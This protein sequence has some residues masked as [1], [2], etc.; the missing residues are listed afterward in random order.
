MLGFRPPDGGAAR[1][2][3]SQV[4]THE[5][6]RPDHPSDE[7]TRRLPSVLVVLVTR[8]GMGWLRGCLASLSRQTYPRLGIIAVD[9]GSTD[10]SRELL[11][12]VLGEA[13]VIQLDANRGF[14][15]SVAAALGTRVASRADYLLLLH[16]DV[17]LDPDAVERLVEAAERVHGAGIVGP[18]VVEWED[19]VVLREVGLST[20]RFG[21]A[22]SPLEEGEIDHGQYDRLREVL[23]VSSC[24]MLVSRDAWGRIGPPDERL[25]ERFDDLDYCW[26]ARL[27][28]FR[29]LVAPLARVRHRAAT[30]RIERTDSEPWAGRGRYYSERAALAAMLKNYSLLSLLWIMPLYA[31][32]SVGKVGGLIAS[33]RFEDAAQVVRA[34]AWNLLRLPGTVRRRVRAQ[35][36]RA[37][38]DRAVRRY[39]ASAGLRLRRWLDVANQLLLGRA[40]ARQEIDEEEETVPTAAVEPLRRRAVSVARD[41]PVGVAWALAVPV[42]LLAFRSFI[43][44]DPLSGG[45]LAAF[46]SSAGGFFRELASGVRTTGLGGTTAASPAL[47][48]LGGLSWLAFGSPALSQ[49]LLLVL[50]PALAGFTLYRSVN[51]RTGRPSAA[52]IAAACYALSGL[53]LW[54]ISEGRVE[55]LVLLAAL[56]PLGDRVA[57]AFGPVGAP[58]RWRFAVGTG[59]LLAV[60][61]AFAPGALLAFGLL[62][63]AQLLVG[64]EGDRLRGLGLSLGGAA[65]AGVLLLPIVLEAAG[66]SGAALGTLVGEADFGLLARLSPTASP[67]GWAVS[68]FLPAAAVLG[69]A[70]AEGRSER[71]A[72]AHLL[73][74]IAAPFL[75]WGSAAGYLPAGASNAPAYLAVAA[76]AYCSLIGLGLDSVLAGMGR[77]AFGLHQ[78]AILVMVGLVAGGLGLQTIR[79]AAGDWAVGPDRL[80]PAWPVVVAEEPER[81]FRVVWIGEQGRGPLPAPAGDADGQVAAGPAWIRYAVRDRSGAVA[82]DIGRRATGDGYAYVE[83]VLQTVLTGEA[84]HGG[85]LLAPLGVRYVVAAEGALPGW[86]LDRLGT[87]LDLDRIPAGGLVIFRNAAALPRASLVSDAGF[88]DAASA[89]DLLLVAEL[90]P[91]L[92]GELSPA[93]GGYSADVGTPSPRAGYV[94][95]A[96][97]YAPGWRLRTGSGEEEPERAFGWAVGFP[98]ESGGDL[99]VVYADQGSRTLATIGL[100]AVWLAALWVT[101]KPSRARSIRPGA[102]LESVDEPVLEAAP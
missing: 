40:G 99:G 6:E 35:S 26:R 71:P 46:P 65:V 74:G 44:P 101:R 33:R 34:W 15:G 9:N 13:R 2:S 89:D 24:A 17:L 29:V 52:V 98:V 86:A 67:G 87:Q 64:G 92:V 53:A 12:R 73:V 80:P 78:V 36:V 48:I 96:D 97:Q 38:P 20:D 88:R 94:L 58:R 19:P 10:G 30:Q 22:Y 49:K 100:A 27:A 5:P 75:A 56:P 37:V 39:M 3:M 31:I 82:T 23:F 4:R 55:S 57:L 8:D 59:V 68:W 70:M 76:V 14:P 77:H 90:R 79:A 83:R 93:P 41:H 16:D 45:S 21:Y 62:L 7:E 72:V 102:P 66:T 85:A 25:A 51:R 54:G 63:V 84:R 28:G 18:K 1:I 61:G 91:T 60:A 81:S 47:G 50:L 69:F 43:G 95:L 42:A 32:Q 11:T